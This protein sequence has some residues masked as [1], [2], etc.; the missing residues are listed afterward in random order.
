MSECRK[1]LV[2]SLPVIS[3]VSWVRDVEESTR[4]PDAKNHIHRHPDA[5]WFDR[6]APTTGLRR[7]FKSSSREELMMEERPAR[8]PAVDCQKHGL[9]YQVIWWYAST[10][11]RALQLLL[12]RLETKGGAND[13]EI[14]SV[15]YK[16]DSWLWPRRKRLKTSSTTRVKLNPDSEIHK[17]GTM[18][19]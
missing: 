1:R 14:S 11:G 8:L 6:G 5:R 18:S 2:A 4:Q 17:M 16:T 12:I 13:G 19:S 10:L 15:V 9:T 3:L 7:I